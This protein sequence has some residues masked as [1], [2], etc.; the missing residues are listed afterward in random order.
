MG[1]SQRASCSICM[2]R[3]DPPEIRPLWTAT[4]DSSKIPAYQ[5]IM[6]KYKEK[7]LLLQKEQFIQLKVWLKLSQLHCVL[8]FYGC[9]IRIKTFICLIY[10][11]LACCSKQKDWISEA[12]DKRPPSVMTP[13]Q[14]AENL[15]NLVL[16]LILQYALFSSVLHIT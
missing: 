10:L 6:E 14:W 12:V 11:H 13:L 7:Q 2:G 9:V 8:N 1:C 15:G 3:S 4:V 16:S 5:E